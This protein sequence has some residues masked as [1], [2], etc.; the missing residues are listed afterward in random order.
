MII[1]LI[2]KTLSEKLLEQAIQAVTLQKMSIFEFRNV[3]KKTSE[4]RNF[5]K[6]KIEAIFKNKA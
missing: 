6:I 3:W 2:T 4:I 5:H 1:I